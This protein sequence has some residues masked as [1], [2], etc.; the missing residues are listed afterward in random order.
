VD[1]PLKLLRPETAPYRGG[2]SDVGDVTLVAPCATLRFPSRIPGE[3]PGHHW[4][5]VTNGISS[6]AHKGI[7]LGAK[8]ACGAAYDLLVKPELLA[9]A[10]QEFAEFSGKN[11]YRAFL[12][13]DSEPPLGWN[14]S[15]MGRYRAEMEKFYIT[16]D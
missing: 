9:Q 10:K 6:I 15:L 7:T 13:S 14:A 4:T 2:S 1:Y 16:P 8:V 5:V 11:P 3:F 12:P